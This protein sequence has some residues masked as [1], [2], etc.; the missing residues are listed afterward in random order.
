MAGVSTLM[1]HELYHAIGFGHD[2]EDE[3]NGMYPISLKNVDFGYDDSKKDGHWWEW[4][5]P[6]WHY[7]EWEDCRQAL[8]TI[9]AIK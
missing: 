4:R 9:G 3:E 2:P 5:V 1:T 7:W 8:L 6:L